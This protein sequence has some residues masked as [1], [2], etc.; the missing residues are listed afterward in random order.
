MFLKE[1]KRS[2]SKDLASEIYLVE[3]DEDILAMK[4]TNKNRKMDE[5]RKFTSETKEIGS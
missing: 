1:T 5:I 2:Q 4:K 3:D